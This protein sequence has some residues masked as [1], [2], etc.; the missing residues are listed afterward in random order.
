MF[1]IKFRAIQQ[2]FV[3]VTMQKHKSTFIRHGAR[4]AYGV[5]VQENQDEKNIFAM[6]ITGH[7]SKSCFLIFFFLKI[8]KFSSNTFDKIRST[9]T[10]KKK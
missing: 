2:D 9:R 4:N 5:G 6:P 3:I 10:D 8:Q 7:S 1:R